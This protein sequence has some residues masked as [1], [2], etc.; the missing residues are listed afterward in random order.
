[1]KRLQTKKSWM[2]G[3]KGVYALLLILP[4]VVSVVLLVSGLRTGNG[5]GDTKR[6]PPIGDA[7]PGRLPDKST[8]SAM[9]RLQKEADK[10]YFA[11]KLNTKPRFAD[12]HSEGT[13]WIE[14]PAH[15]PYPF[16]VE[17][18]LD[19]TG[20]KVYDSG[21]IPPDHHITAAALMKPLP[22]GSHAATA[23]LLVYDPDTLEY[24]GQAA[25][26]LLLIV[27]ETV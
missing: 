25:V 22:K 3:I 10:S 24:R 18:Y 11:F 20:E 8:E 5:T 27:L 21:G 23:Y 4:V 17:I 1:M 26:E 12:G 7:A 15:N 16:V 13:L 6:L 14:N 2:T 9:E 19:Q